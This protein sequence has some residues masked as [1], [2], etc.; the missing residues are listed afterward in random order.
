MYRKTLPFAALLVLFT[1]CAPVGAE[2]PVAEP[3]VAELGDG[4]AAE[5]KGL[6]DIE[7]CD[8]EDYRPLIGTG[9]AAA[10]LP[11]DPRLRAYGVN[12]I[13]TQEYIPQRT[14]IVYGTDGIIQRVYCG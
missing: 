9:I 6:A 8:A 11:E 7:L 12:D 4:G 1:A 14:N 5:T 2:P 10:A 3:D 13:I